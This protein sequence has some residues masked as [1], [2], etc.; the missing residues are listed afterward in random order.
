[1][2]RRSN[3]TYITVKPEMVVHEIEKDKSLNLIGAPVQD[4][5][6]PA[7]SRRGDRRVAIVDAAESLFLEQGY[8]R[9]SLAAII[10]RS[11]GSLATVYELFGNKQGLLR[12][13]VERARD[14][15][16][17]GS[18]MCER[19]S[20]AEMLREFAYR[21]SEHMTAP[22]SIALMRVVI[23]ESL[24]DPEF[25]RGSTVYQN[26]NGD[27]AAGG[28]NP[29]LGPIA[30]AP[31]YALRLY[32]SDIG[33]SAGLVTDEFSRVLDTHSRPIVGLYACG[34]DMQSVMG[35]TYPGPGIT[36][37]PALAFAYLAASDATA[38][39]AGSGERADR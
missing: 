26:H 13:V 7:D 22:R 18:G 23:A 36:L 37:G 11:G 12:A 10:K 35:G 32:P 21:L 3:V 16:D 24:R 31:F 19:E 20:G 30:T 9:T 2:D 4:R 6:E 5:P 27:A 34:N 28:A 39:L 29:N 17:I 1:M 38:R 15:G 14:M 33:T 8:E 25:G